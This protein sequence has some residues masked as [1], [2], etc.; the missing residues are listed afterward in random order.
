VVGSFFFLLPPTVAVIL[1]S[2]GEGGA[3]RVRCG[4]FI[5][6][7]L[8][9]GGRDGG[10]T[11]MQSPYP[12]SGLRD[13]PVRIFWFR[14]KW[15]FWFQDGTLLFESTGPSLCSPVRPSARLTFSTPCDYGHDH[16][17]GPKGASCFVTPRLSNTMNP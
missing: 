13:L 11:M 17:L 10:G 2:G 16:R 9:W 14:A 8:V 5:R 1:E 4:I 3:V 12:S 7:P 6:I 15:L